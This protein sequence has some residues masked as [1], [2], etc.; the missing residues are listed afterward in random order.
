M[1]CAVL[2]IPH[3]PTSFS[4][5]NQTIGSAVADVS[6]SF[7]VQAARET[8]AENEEDDTSHITACYDG[9]W[10]KYGH[11]FVNGIIPA[12]SADRMKASDI[13]IMNK[14]PV[15]CHTSPISQHECKKNHEGASG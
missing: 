9:T 8:V 6:V 7:I 10:Q 15:V 1:L 13:E 2:N 12:T 5:Y 3:P 14:F 4:I 11:I